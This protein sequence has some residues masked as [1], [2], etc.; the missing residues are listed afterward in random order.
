MNL[1]RYYVLIPCGIIK[2]MWS[3]KKKERMISVKER[4]KEREPQEKSMKK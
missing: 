4:K 3:M 2:E 1:L